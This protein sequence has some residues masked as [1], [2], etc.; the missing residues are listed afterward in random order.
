MGLMVGG[1]GEWL[2]GLEGDAAQRHLG[3]VLA[4]G[5]TA[6][7]ANVDCGVMVVALDN[8]NGSVPP[9]EALVNILPKPTNCVC[10][11]WDS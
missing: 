10:F 1:L 2:Y 9:E 7:C 6:S 3:L 11:E 4:C 8:V 5:G